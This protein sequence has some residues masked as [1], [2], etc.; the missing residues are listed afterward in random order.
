MRPTSSRSL[1]LPPARAHFWLLTARLY[2][3]ASS[4]TKN[5]LNGTMPATVNSTVGSCGIRLAD[6]TTV[7]AR[8]AKK[9]SEGVA[10]LIGVLWW[11]SHGVASLPR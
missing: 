11:R 1:C 9:S 2:G 4:P 5:G 8:A 10:E 3:G 6:G 7:W